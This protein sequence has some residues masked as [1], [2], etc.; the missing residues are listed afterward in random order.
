MGAQFEFLEAL[1][2]Q[3]PPQNAVPLNGDTFIRLAKQ[4]Q[5]TLDCFLSHAARGLPVKGDVD[6]CRHASCSLFE[7]DEEG[8]QLRAMRLL[9]RFKNFTYAFLLKLGPEAGLALTGSKKHVDLWMFK[10]FNPLAAVT[11]VKAM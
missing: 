6:P 8:D 7:H 4:D 10:G 11:A 1:P 9:P 2:P 5:P 3:C